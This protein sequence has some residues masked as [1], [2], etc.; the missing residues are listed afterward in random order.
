MASKEKAGKGGK[1]GG[2]PRVLGTTTDGVRILKPKG[3]ATHFTAKEL[4]DAVASA[5]ALRRA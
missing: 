1:G 2:G 3:K 5:R 4:R